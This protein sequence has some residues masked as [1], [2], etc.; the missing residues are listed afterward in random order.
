[1]KI[2][3]KKIDEN[4]WK[5]FGIYLDRNDLQDLEDSIRAELSEKE[6]LEFLEGI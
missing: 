6:I 1:M 2:K 4:C 5:L 3:L